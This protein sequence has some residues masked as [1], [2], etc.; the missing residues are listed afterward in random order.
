MQLAGNLTAKL[1]LANSRPFHRDNFMHNTRF[2]NRLPLGSRP[3][4]GVGHRWASP[5]LALEQLLPQRA[6]ATLRHL[7][8]AGKTFSYYG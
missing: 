8:G 7:L 5:G 2:I 3:G 4:R 6:A 1:A